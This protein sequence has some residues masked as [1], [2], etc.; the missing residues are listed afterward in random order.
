MILFIF[1]SNTN[2]LSSQNCFD[3]ICQFI[4]L[5]C[6]VMDILHQVHVALGIPWLVQINSFFQYL[7]QS[8]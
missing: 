5:Q 3:D 1:H 8:H 4:S 7:N 6:E 2:L